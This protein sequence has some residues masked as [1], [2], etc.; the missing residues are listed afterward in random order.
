MVF[1]NKNYNVDNNA[2]NLFPSNIHLS[3]YKKI[4]TLRIME[5]YLVKFKNNGKIPSSLYLSSGQECATAALSESLLGY[6]I[7]AQHRSGDTY[8]SFGGSIEAFRDEVLGFSTGCSQGKGGHFGI[9]WHDDK[10]DMFGDNLLIGECVPRAVGAALDNNKKTLCIFGDGA[11]EEDYVLESLGFASTYR[12][13][14]VFVCTDNDL[15]I[16]THV[17]ERRSWSIVDVSK[18]FGINTF[19]MADDPW[20]IMKLLAIDNLKLPIFLNIHVCRKYWHV[21][22]GIDGPSEWDRNDIVRKQ[23]LALGY[24]KDLEEIDKHVE[25]FMKGVWFDETI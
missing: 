19:E 3:V 7:F 5:K 8:L 16:L 20:T 21:G 18:S 12:L 13:P 22:T 10:L 17:K 1:R 14:I 23:L 2:I 9:Q 4:T 25:I 15:A 6:Q 24:E 11:A